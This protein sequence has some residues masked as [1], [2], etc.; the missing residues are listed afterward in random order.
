MRRHILE[1]TLP[2]LRIIRSG[3]GRVLFGR[4][5]IHIESER[6]TA[7][8]LLDRVEFRI[9]LIEQAEREAGARNV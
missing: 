8:G 3:L 9:G 2:E 7:V 6:R 1:L 4:E 5:S